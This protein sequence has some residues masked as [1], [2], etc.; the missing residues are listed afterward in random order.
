MVQTVSEG[1][2][3]RY[4]FLKGWRQLKLEDVTTCRV[5]LMQALDIRT[6]M[7]FCRRRAGKVIPTWPEKEAIERV[8]ASFGVT[9]IWGR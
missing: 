1:E 7:S 5:R 8:F 2:E 9:D 6:R 3:M 4:S